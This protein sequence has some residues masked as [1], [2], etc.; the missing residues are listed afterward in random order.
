[1]E[2]LTDV[3]FLNVSVSVLARLYFF[4]NIGLQVNISCA[5]TAKITVTSTKRGMV[6]LSR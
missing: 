3:E 2:K 1:M 4:T 6:I 5:S